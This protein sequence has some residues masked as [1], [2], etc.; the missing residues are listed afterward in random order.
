MTERVD[1]YVLK[2]ADV[3]QRW[4][5]ACRLT[6]KAYLKDLKIVIVNDTLADAK[7]LDELLWTFNEQSFIPH[8]ICL[9][10]QSVDPATPVHLTVESAAL[11]AADLLVNLAHRLPAQLERYARIAEIIDADEE[12]RRLGRERFK[13]YRDLKLTLETH[14]IDEA[15]DV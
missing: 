5:F 14:Q 10:E 13:A 6:E 12:R 1:F 11:P 3:K 2:S 4:A 9:D 8:Q 7:A 15:A